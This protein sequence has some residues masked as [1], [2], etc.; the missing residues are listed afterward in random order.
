[1]ENTLRVTL[2]FLL[3]AIKRPDW[4]I[5]R[6]C[7]AVRTGRLFSSESTIHL[8]CV[9]QNP[10]TFCGLSSCP[11]RSE[12]ASP[13]SHWSPFVSRFVGTVPVAPCPHTLPHHGS[14]KDT[15]VCFPAISLRFHVIQDTAKVATDRVRG[16]FHLRP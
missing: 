11:L 13:R 10:Q 4:R 9:L 3:K 16:S 7:T 2:Y 6:A 5:F 1:M 15:L 12:A 8:E 14:P